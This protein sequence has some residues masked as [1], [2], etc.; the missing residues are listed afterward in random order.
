LSI[1]VSPNFKR[2][3]TPDG[4]SFSGAVFAGTD[5]AGLYRSLDGGQSWQALALIS[6]DAIINALFFDAQGVLYMG[7]GNHGIQASYDLGD[8]WNTL[9][10]TEAVILCLAAHGSRLL[11]G[12]AEDGLLVFENGLFRDVSD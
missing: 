2:T 11:A 6:T 9:L 12:T 5:G 4:A 7:T 3:S 1:A 10:E 8:T